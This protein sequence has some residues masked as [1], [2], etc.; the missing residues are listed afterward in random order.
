MDE[1]A[2][3]GAREAARRIREGRL[4]PVAL[5]EA[6]LERITALDGQLKAWSH[7]DEA[8]A[9]NVA[10]AREAEARSGRIVG[11]LHGV[12]VGIKDIIDVAGMPTTGGARPWAHTRPS[13][14]A[15]CVA[16]LRAAG[17][18]ILGK[19]ATTEFAY[20]DPAPTHNPWHPAHTPGGSSAG[21]G[22]AV[23]ARMVPLA[24]GSQTVGSVLRP[25][26]YCGVVGFKGT[27]GAVPVDGVIALA[28]SLDHIGVFGRTV[29]DA[30]L[31]F[32]ILIDRPLDPA[33]PRA[34]RLALAPEL[35]ARAAPETAARIQAAADQFARAG[36]SVVEVKL[37]ASFDDV[38]AAGLTVLEAEAAAYHADNFRRHAAEYGPEIR[39]LVDAGLKQAAPTFV[40]ANR[41]RL[42]FRDEMVPLLT[43]HHAL[44]AP[45]APAPAPAGLHST[46]DGSLCAPWSYTGVPA[47]TLPSGLDGAGLPEAIQLVAAAG[48]EALLFDVAQ[49]CEDALGF[50]AA[51]SL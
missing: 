22:A 35:L 2:R 5:A 29:T 25:A 34:P 31:G 30:A 41:A 28:W 16:R 11:P 47:I 6:C 32:G 42:R 39:A 44:L 23:A 46:G 43:S 9:L 14:D 18:V 51:P 15:T 45:T 33:A 24:L 10:R 4:S 48:Q 40:R 12:A 8:G 19:T 37:P 38:H 27:H 1:A 49:W 7:L 20:R 3:L 17:A 50:S 21:S 13:R 26:A 36:A